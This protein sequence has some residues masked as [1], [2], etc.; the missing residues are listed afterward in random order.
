M[1]RCSRCESEGVSLRKESM[2]LSHDDVTLLGLYP[3]KGMT[4]E[5]FQSV[6]MEIK[7]RV[8]T[9]ATLVIDEGA[10]LK[11]GARLYQENSARSPRTS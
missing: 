5:H 10:D 6:L 8:G 3:V 7:E 1:S 4:G 2:I 9:I 11:K